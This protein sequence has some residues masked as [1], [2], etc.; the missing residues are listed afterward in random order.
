MT[1][2]VIVRSTLSP[3]PAPPPVPTFNL[4]PVASPSAV[5]YP[6]PPLVITTLVGVLTPSPLVNR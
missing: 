4:V 2:L 1:P 6:D 3:L 5:L